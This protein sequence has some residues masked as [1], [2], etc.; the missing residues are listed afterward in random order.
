RVTG[1]LKRTLQT[2]TTPAPIVETNVE[3]VD[4]KNLP[5]VWQRLMVM[6]NARGPSL[7]S[8]LCHGELV[9]IEDG[10][11]IIRYQKQ[12]A[13]F[14]K[15]LDRNGKKEIVG[16][17]LSQ[18]TGQALGVKFDVAEQ[19]EADVATAVATAPPRA[20]KPVHR[21]I[22]RPTEAPATSTNVVRIT[23]ELV[24]SLKETEPLIK[25]L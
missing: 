9:G 20:Q 14:V 19:Q 25:A 18:V 24:A 2:E 15:L 3:P 1:P 17:A 5:A 4:V 11:A 7:P 16:E 8:L 10:R 12:H 22:A 23:P 13:T 21:E 6:L